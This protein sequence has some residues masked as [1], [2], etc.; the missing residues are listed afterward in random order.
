MKIKGNILIVDDDSYILFSLQSLLERHFTNVLIRKDP[1]EIPSVI[2]DSSIDVLILDMNFSSGETSGEEGLKWIN[3]V[4][5]LDQHISIVPITAYGGVNMAVEALK[6]GAVDFIVKPWQNEKMLS[7]ITSAFNFSKSKRKITQLSEQNSLL[8]RTSNIEN[9]KIIGESSVM[10]RIF[11]K[12]EKVAKTDANVLIL[13]ENGTGKELFAR[14]IHRESLRKA[15]SFINVDLGSISETL[16]E[17]ELFGH[18]KGAYTDAKENRI[19][20]LEAADQGTLFLDE[21]GNIP[22]ILQ[23][24]LL[25]VLQNREIF[26]LGSNQAIPIDTRLVS[27]TNQDIYSMVNTGLFRNDL[28]YRINTVEIIIPPLR[29]RPEDIPFIANFFVGKYSAKYKKRIKPLSNQVIK[30]L[31]QYD[32]PGN[33]RE[34]QHSVEKAVILYDGSELLVD[35]FTFRREPTALQ[36]IDDYNL[37]RIEKNAIVNCLAKHKGNITKAAEE[38]GLTRGAIYRRFEK[39]GI[40]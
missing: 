21:I 12:V 29:N 22:F 1:D 38:L 32:W 19:G 31:Q 8:N 28:F 14:M 17:S 36:L 40:T 6:A 34:L 39:H 7:T 35:D 37:D 9:F 25:S 4:Y 2:H 24:K 13:G 23:N 11:E 5:K 18:L 16:F 30:R 20:R 3:T 27:A 26:R 10:K 15:Q 33:V